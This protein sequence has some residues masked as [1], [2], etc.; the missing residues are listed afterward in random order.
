[1][2]N[3]LSSVA[4][5]QP[6]TSFVAAFAS[7]SASDDDDVDVADAAPANDDDDD[8]DDA[9]AVSHHESLFPTTFTF[10]SVFF[11]HLSSFRI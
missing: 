10:F 5:L 9:A 2:I 1:M 7:A 4:K 11:I 8:D 3:Y 6:M